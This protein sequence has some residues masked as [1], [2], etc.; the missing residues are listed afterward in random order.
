MT[1]RLS[2]NQS[3]QFAWDSTSLGALKTC[4]R[5]YQ[6][7]ILEGWQPKAQSFHL[8][9]GI[10]YH[11]GLEVYDQVQGDHL[12]KLCAALRAAIEV[13]TEPDGSWWETYDSAKSVPNLIRSII[14]YC[15]QFEDD[16][17][18]TVILANGKPAVEL[19]FRL[20]IDEDLILCGHLD[21]L[22][23]FG[24]AYWVMDRKTTK[25]QLGESYFA[26]FNPSNQMTLYY[27]ASSVVLAKPVTG[28]IIDAAQIL[29]SGTR[30]GRHLTRRTKAEVEEFFD[31]VKFWTSLASHFYKSGFWPMNDNAC[32][33]YGGCPFRVVC[34]APESHRQAILA[35]QFT[36]SF[37]DPLVTR[38]V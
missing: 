19:S 14:W 29:V 5:K 33:N 1:S 34:T 18:E 17:A 12:T 37:W 9:F 20:P 36:K 8:R 24:N 2:F 7:S 6:L 31:A 16:A 4:P 3:G 35:T 28:V 13:C 23:E 22:V 26:Q 25:S 10:A 15:D 32:S 30:F 38:E 11:K 27:A 21:R